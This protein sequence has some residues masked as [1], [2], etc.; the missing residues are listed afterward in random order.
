[1]LEARDALVA[2]I[3]PALSLRK[4][5]RRGRAIS[6]A[7]RVIRPKRPMQMSQIAKHFIT[8]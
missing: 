6:Q 1:V 3:A 7:L 5:L 8:T 2:V 4:F